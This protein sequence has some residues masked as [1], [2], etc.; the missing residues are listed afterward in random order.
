MLEHLFISSNVTS[1]RKKYLYWVC[2]RLPV[3]GYRAPTFLQ[4]QQQKQYS[5]RRSKPRKNFFNFS[6]FS[7]FSSAVVSDPSP[8]NRKM[9]EIS[10]SVPKKGFQVLISFI[11]QFFISLICDH[12]HF[13]SF[14]LDFGRLSSLS[15]HASLHFSL[16]LSLSLS[17]SHT[18]TLT[19][20]RPP[21]FL[22]YWA[23]GAV[24]FKLSQKQ[25]QH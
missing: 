8:T 25:Q 3:H 7:F 9:S 12:F 22:F 14:S 10:V 2:R 11:D 17:L 24:F 20:A 6:A 19:H 13:S 21:F 18:H 4:Q 16:S 5:H 23:K 1:C 15:Q